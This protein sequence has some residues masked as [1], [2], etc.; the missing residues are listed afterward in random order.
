MNNF[1][2]KGIHHV[3]C[4]PQADHKLEKTKTWLERAV[5]LEPRLGDAWAY[6][7]KYVKQYGQPD[8][9]QRIVER[10]DAAKPTL[11][12]A[13]RAI[14]KSLQWIQAND[15]STETLLKRVAERLP[16]PQ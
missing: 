16:D 12:D 15:R 13:W 4:V 1:V 3:A 8:A 6:L 7:Y 10:C 11:G 5:Q 2:V 14:S 9:L